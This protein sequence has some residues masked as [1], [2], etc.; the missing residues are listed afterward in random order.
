MGVQ[1]L[2]A[3]LQAEEGAQ[4]RDPRLWSEDGCPS[5]QEEV[6]RNVGVQVC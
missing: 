3:G 6:G 2:R 1:D 4:H 5:V